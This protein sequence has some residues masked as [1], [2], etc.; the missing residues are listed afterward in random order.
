VK[1]FV[2]RL[3]RPFFSRQ[4]AFNQELLAEIVAIRDALVQ[5][6]SLRPT[7]DRM[8]DI[9]ARV[10]QIEEWMRFDRGRIER[11]DWAVEAI[12]PVLEQRGYSIDAMKE[13]LEDLVNDRELMR[14][15]VELAHQQS[16]ARFHDGLG[17]IRTE[18]NDLA[19][20]L[21]R[22]EEL[23][24]IRRAVGEV[25]ASVGGALERRLADFQMRLSQVDILLNRVRSSLPADTPVASLAELPGAF[26]N[27][28]GPFEEA[29]R[30]STEIIKERVKLYLPDML[31]NPSTAPVLDVGCGRGELLAVLGEAGIPAY[32]IEINSGYAEL[33]Q[34]H[35]LDVRLVD[36]V[37]HL[38]TLRERSIRAI[39]AIQ[40]AEHLTTDQLIEFLDLA[41]RALEPGGLLILETPN[42]ENL[43]VGS[44]SFY[45]DPTHQRPLPPQ[46]LAFLVGARG[47][48]DIEIRMLERPELVGLPELGAGREWA[49]DLH[50][51]VS[52]LNTRMFNAQDYAILARRV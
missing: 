13:V 37:E 46:L 25:R 50:P 32:G 33:A 49:D 26:D 14:E 22:D 36:V 43:L 44:S 47:F 29:L 7:G 8:A 23:E 34:E 17:S 45:L 28:Y 30:G 24:D 16:F 4:I 9:E 21:S 1:R 41:I 48:T 52:L 10:G 3:C 6:I 27:L 38:R 31:A 39:T 2:A 20:Q 15:E 19:Q 12:L 51:I 11:H 5:E 42:P 40:V 35:G 18:M